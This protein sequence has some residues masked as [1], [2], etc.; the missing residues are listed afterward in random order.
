MG[1]DFIIREHK[2]LPWYDASEFNPIGSVKGGK[3]LEQ[4]VHV[5]D[6]EGYL[7]TIRRVQVIS[8][9]LSIL[10]SR[11]ATS[12][13]TRINF[14]FCIKVLAIAIFAPSFLFTRLL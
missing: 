13:S 14:G 3:V 10:R 1:V 2:C 11:L 12:S 8:E 5:S 9:L 4:I 6:D 7:S